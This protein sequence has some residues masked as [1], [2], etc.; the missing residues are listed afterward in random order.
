MASH[1]SPSFPSRAACAA[2][3][4]RRALLGTLFALAPLA[5]ADG[6]DPGAAVS[7]PDAAAAAASAPATT[8]TVTGRVPDSRASIAGF[9]DTPPDRSP[10]Q[11][12]AVPQVQIRDSGGIGLSA[13]TRFDASVSDAYNA[14]GYWTDF[15]VRG[16]ALDN[17][18]NFLRDG[19]PVNAETSLPLDNKSSVEI[20]KG[21]SGIQ[22]GTSAP[23]GLVNLVV[24]R[25]GGDFRSA[26]VDWREGGTV[27]TWVDLSQRF[28]PA[29]TFG[30]RV[31]AVAEHLAPKVFDDKGR[32]T[33]FALAGDWHLSSGGLLQVEIESSRQSQPSVPG[34]SMLGPQLPA[35][36]S[37]DP[38][39]NLNNQP[40]TLPVVLEG[41]TG[42][43]RLQQPL[44][45][46]WRL[47]L[48][49]VEQRLHSDDRLDFSY[50]C[51]K[52]AYTDRYCS[53]GSFDYYE[54]RSDAERRIDDALDLH[55]SGDVRT[56]AL[57]HQLSF[58]ALATRFRLRTQPQADDGVIVGSGTVDGLT[59]VPALPAD[60]GVIPNTDRT[61]RSSELYARDQVQLASDFG[62]W[63]GLR[64]T[65][66][67]RASVQTDG[68]HATDYG[69]S[70]TT[71]WLA[72][73][74]ALEGARL[75]YASW[76][77][78]VESAVAPN[79]AGYTN[80]G[81]PLPAVTSRQ[82]E[83]GLKQAGAAFGWSVDWFDIRRPLFDDVVSTCSDGSTGCL[84]TQLDGLTHNHGLEAGLR[85]TRG[86]LELHAGLMVLR[87]TIVGNSNPVLDGKVP[88]NVPQRTLK[89]DTDYAVTTRPGL[90][91]QAGMVFED[92]RMV[93][94][95]NSAAIPGW[96]RWDLGAS[97]RMRAG[98]TTLTWRLGVDNAA[99]RRAW[100]ESPF[101]YGHVY[102][103]PL[104]PRTWRAALQVDL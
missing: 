77:R 14:D 22:A 7:A 102:L 28:G 34:F 73:T 84:T 6:T 27:G 33:L 5:H 31:N 81:Q 47:V 63:F 11:I 74:R 50:G 30:V 91:L 38:R 61:E 41:T 82:Y 80:R 15:T 43:L 53:D 54:Y 18:R 67:E 36:R 51:S 40:W 58:G 9:G 79:L 3:C 29:G 16:F 48:H 68:T 26:G 64:H 103:F 20:L 39:I 32:R 90:K 59:I 75:I 55:V 70:F 57:R 2:G 85:W 8:V 24:K 65:H 96:T 83:L 76:G 94:P 21:T 37:I 10:L 88:T 46:D 19:L 71:P 49:G 12:A 56:G 23:G 62:L 25:P 104:A 1:S 13:L 87:S 69:Q 78:G 52:E 97:Y 35:A 60:L 44:G 100:R 92:A 99:N 4:I 95:D 42:S 17:Q 45:A 86:Q 98:A 93:L 101:E 72:V 89:L 66:L